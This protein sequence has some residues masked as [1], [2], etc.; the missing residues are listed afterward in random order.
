MSGMARVGF[1]R[2][3]SRIWILALTFSIGVT[4]P[5]NGS[6]DKDLPAITQAFIPAPQ[7]RVTTRTPPMDRSCVAYDPYE[8]NAWSASQKRQV[9]AK[10]LRKTQ[11]RLAVLRARWNIPDFPDDNPAAI[12]AYQNALKAIPS[13][14]QEEQLELMR[15]IHEDKLK[16]MFSDFE[17][18][19]LERD[20]LLRQ[21][22]SGVLSGPSL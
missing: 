15:K 7:Q 13:A 21:R 12:T 6:N 5:P 8:E 17:L 11:K 9:I 4:L 22:C 20:L 14:I 18:K 3:G 16:L 10:R 2:F 19:N 1:L